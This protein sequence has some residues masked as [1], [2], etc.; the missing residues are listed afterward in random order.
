MSAAKEVCLTLVLPSPGRR[1]GV[2]V[3][4]TDGILGGATMI[5]M[6]VIVGSF[7]RRLLMAHGGGFL[8]VDIFRAT[9]PE[10]HEC[11]R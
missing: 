11:L 9:Q 3:H 7:G 8:W 5:S 4:P 2:D 6:S 1:V 10:R